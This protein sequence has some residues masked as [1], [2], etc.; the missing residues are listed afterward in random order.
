MITSTTDLSHF[1]Q[2]T[3]LCDTHEHMNREE[4]YLRENPD[5]LRNLFQNYVSADFWSGGASKAAMD[6][7]VDSSNP[8]VRGRFAAVEETWKGIQHTGYAEAVRLTAKHL[9]DIDEIT[10]EAL[11]EASGRNAEYVK[12][13]KR[14]HILRDLANL[15]HIQTDDGRWDCP[16]DA[17]GPDFFFYDLSWAGFCRG[18]PDLEALEKETGID[19]TN[20]SRLR[21]AMSV[22]FKKHAGNAIAVKSQHAYSRTLSWRER[23]DDEAEKAFQAV[24]REG[25]DASAEAR[26]CLGDW[27]WARGC[28]FCAEHDLPF[29]IHTGYYA[30][31]DRMPVDFIRSGNMCSLLATYPDTRFVLMHIAY[32][33]SHEL[34]ALAKHYRNVYVDLCWAWCID[35]YSSFDFVRRYLHTAPANKLFIFG[36]DTVFPIGALGYS[37]QAR[38]WFTRALEGEVADGLVSEKEAIALAQRLMRDNQFDCFRIES[39]RPA[40]VGS[41]QADPVN[42]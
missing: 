40:I 7:L 34:T 29:K 6:G 24:R 1:I 21:E 9:F 15:D 4:A 8:D 17:S 32:P 28:E 36:G 10:P 20:L 12:P 31:N 14:L 23:S 35:P 26:L 30:G 25:A 37:L 38:Q 13:G 22:L 3:A 41:L 42:A 11:E 27:N 18:V 19:A 33:Y 16:A 39:K 5:I 2:D